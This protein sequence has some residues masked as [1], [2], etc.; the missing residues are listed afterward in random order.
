[1][2]LPDYHVVDKSVL[3][4]PLMVLQ[5]PMH[6]TQNFMDAPTFPCC[7]DALEIYSHIFLCVQQDMQEYWQG[8]QGVLAATLRKIGIPTELK[9]IL[10][11]GVLI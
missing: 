9:D 11:H 6:K 3:L 7:R 2:P 8:Q 1:M 4:H 10:L 5:T